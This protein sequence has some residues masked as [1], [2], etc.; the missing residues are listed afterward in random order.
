MERRT[1]RFAGLIVQVETDLPLFDFRVEQFAPF[2]VPSGSPD[3][4]CTL[5]QANDLALAPLSDR[6]IDHFTTALHHVTHAHWSSPLLKAA[7][8]R[9]RLGDCAAVP[10]SASVEIG[11]DLI[12]IYDCAQ[13]RLD[14]FYRADSPIACTPRY[15]GT[16]FVAP[17][18]PAFDAILLHSAG[19]LGG[20][21]VA[22]LIAP[23]EGGKTTAARL[24]TDSLIL[25]DDQNIV[26][27][28]ADGPCVYGTPWGLHTDSTH[29][30]QLGGLFFLEKT[31]EFDL[32][33]L[34]ADDALQRLWREHGDH[35]SL[36]PPRQRLDTVSLFNR[37][38][39]AVP[40]YR[41]CFPV[42]RVDWNRVDGAMR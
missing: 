40:A 19:V 26:R 32:I 5:R 9:R 21:K 34:P 15:L 2:N 1:Y 23:D 14:L 13:P 16:G 8:V 12:T 28:G 37:L 11:R 17:F 39:H 29:H 38:A 27:F 7:D 25:S 35:F 4:A 30:A 33:P 24:A 31:P 6:E 20:N 10:G 41:L 18:V 3:I 36:L 22:L 42:D